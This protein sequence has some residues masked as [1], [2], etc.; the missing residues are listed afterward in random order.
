MSTE[1][2]IRNDVEV[3]VLGGMEKAADDLVKTLRSVELEEYFDEDFVEYVSGDIEISQIEFDIDEKKSENP[4]ESV[5][6]YLRTSSV[7]IGTQRGNS[8]QIEFKNGKIEPVIKP[9]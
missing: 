1:I 8:E 2:V 4:L 9:K 6:A 5:I 3:D 7:T